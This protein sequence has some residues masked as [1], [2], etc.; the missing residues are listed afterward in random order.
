MLADWASDREL[1]DALYQRALSRKPSAAAAEKL[2][3][4]VRQQP[5]RQRAWE[6]V[7]WTILNSK[8][9]IYQH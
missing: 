9:F 6:D 4:Y 3:A 1:L 7:L 5:D 8:E 2:L